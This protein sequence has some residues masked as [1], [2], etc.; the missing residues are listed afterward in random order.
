M[1]KL[2]NTLK[3]LVD[4]HGDGEMVVL[5]QPVPQVKQAPGMLRRVGKFLLATVSCLDGDSLYSL[6]L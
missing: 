4:S 2:I 5:E 3:Y 1:W 6:T